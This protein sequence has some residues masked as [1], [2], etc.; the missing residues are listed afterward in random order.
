MNDYLFYVIIGLILLVGFIIIGCWI[1]VRKQKRLRE[2][3]KFK[4]VI[5][6]EEPPIN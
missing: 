4:A 5:K 6:E 1:N 2:I 3:L